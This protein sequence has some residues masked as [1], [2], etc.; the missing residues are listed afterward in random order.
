MDEVAN[1]VVGNTVMDTASHEPAFHT[2]ADC[3]RTGARILQA[4]LTALNTT[5]VGFNRRFACTCVYVSCCTEL[6]PD[7]VVVGGQGGDGS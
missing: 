3:V 4:R 1:I 7:S 5:S 6:G 2:W